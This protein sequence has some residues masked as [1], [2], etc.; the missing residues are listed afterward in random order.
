MGES[1]T[2][3]GIALFVLFLIIDAVLYAFS[4]ALGSINDKEL[5]KKVEE[6]NKR[7]VRLK[8]LMDEPSR[9]GDTLDIVVFVTNVVAG[10]YILGVIQ[11]RIGRSVAD[12]SPW[13]KW[14]PVLIA[15][16]MLLILIV[17]GVLIPKKCGKRS[18]GKAAYT[19]SGTVCAVI[20]LLFP[21]TK[22]VTLISHLFLRIFGIDPNEKT[23]NVT[24]EE[25]IT[26]VNEGQEQGVLEASEAEMIANIFE[27]GD[28]NAGD[29]MTHRSAIVALDGHM[30]LEEVIQKH[31]DG[32]YSRFPVYDGDIDN[33]VGT[34]HIRDALIMYR[35]LPNRKKEISKL[36][37]IIRPAY[38]VPDTRDIDDLLK[39]M[40]AEKIHMGIVVDE[41]G[42]T[43]GVISME[44]II[45]E[46]VGNILDE[47]DVE[48]DSIE[49][50]SDDSYIVDGLTE[51]ED[52]NK[53][54]GTEIESEDF[55]TLNGYL[56]SLLNRIP[57]ENETAEITA[58]GYVFR[59]LEVSG[60]VIRRVEVVK[61]KEEDEGENPDENPPDNSQTE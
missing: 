4:A 47:Y 56:I 1:Q 33:I 31:I 53:L 9:F 17:F 13:L 39:D 34:L 19:L 12:D 2:Y 14:L 24:E 59:I 54:I 6:G 11:R 41:Y 8:K 7:A 51:L 21:F 60:N 38:F 5:D 43:A 46:I 18:A 29:I 3:I 58:D 50:N 36:K 42:Q 27:L 55:D 23:D 49:H 15:L 28:K 35:N 45:E 61:E 40:Q 20:I 48:E 57:E 22:A 37:S 26:M 52:L 10:A 16:T 32:N 25:I 44:D 30:T